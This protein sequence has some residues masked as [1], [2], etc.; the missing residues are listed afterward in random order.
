MEWMSYNGFLQKVNKNIFNWKKVHKS[1]NMNQLEWKPD[2]NEFGNMAFV[3]YLVE[4][5]VNVNAKSITRHTAL[6]FAAIFGLYYWYSQQRNFE[7]TDKNELNCNLGHLDEV[8]YLIGK[9]AH[10][11][12]EDISGNT[13]LHAAA[14]AGRLEIAKYL[15][16]HGADVNARNSDGKTAQKIASGNGN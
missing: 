8:Q 1:I 4:H 13:P 9:G 5:G 12:A 11:N 3:N 15:V 14:L 16:A 6:H 10:V 7:S 2:G